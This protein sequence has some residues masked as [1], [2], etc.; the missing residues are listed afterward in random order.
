MSEPRTGIDTARAFYLDHVAVRLDGLPH[1]AA[2]IGDG[3]EVLGF[4]A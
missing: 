1:A 2:L 4:E 3:S